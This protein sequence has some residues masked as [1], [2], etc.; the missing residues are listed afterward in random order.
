[1]NEPL[2][3]YHVGGIGYRDVR[4][5]YMLR[6]KKAKE[7]LKTI[8]DIYEFRPSRYEEYITEV[9][10]FL[11]KVECKH[12][13]PLQEAGFEVYKDLDALYLYKINLTK[14]IDKINY[15]AVQSTP[16]QLEYDNKYWAKFREKTVKEIDYIYGLDDVTYDLIKDTIYGKAWSED[17]AKKQ[18]EYMLLRDN[19]LEKKYGIKKYMTYE[20]FI[21]LPYLDDWADLDKY[22]ELNLKEGAKGQYA[23]LVPHVQVSVKKP[24]EIEEVY[25]IC[26]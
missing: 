13:K 1:M 25:K 26:E 8:K 9:N 18:A 22:W 15:I 17:F 23:S 7:H 21:R 16:Q 12:L 24:L 3:I 5:L 4:P 10:A 14:Q 11:G 19:Y 20:E 6:T 2:Y